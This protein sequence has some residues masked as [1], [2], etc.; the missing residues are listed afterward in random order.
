MRLLS[1]GFVEGKIETA[2][3]IKDSQNNDVVTLDCKSD[4]C[5]PLKSY[6]SEAFPQVVARCTT[7]R[8]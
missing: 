7:L 6:G 1:E 3:S 5:A 4:G 2:A 8:E